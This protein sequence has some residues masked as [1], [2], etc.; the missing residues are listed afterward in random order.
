[1][2]VDVLTEIVIDRPIAEVAAYAADPTHAPD[3]CRVADGLR[4]LA[5][6]YSSRYGSRPGRQ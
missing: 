1:V 3:W 2:A 5:Y 4:R 6:A